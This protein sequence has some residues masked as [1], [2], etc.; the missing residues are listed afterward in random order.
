M[1]ITPVSKVFPCSK[2]QVFIYY[3]FFA[4]YYLPKFASAPSTQLWYISWKIEYLRTLS[5]GI[6]KYS[7]IVQLNIQQLSKW[8]V[9]FISVLA[10]STRYLYPSLKIGY[11]SIFLRGIMNHLMSNFLLLQA[12]IIYILVYELWDRIFFLWYYDNISQ[13]PN[14]LLLRAPRFNIQVWKSNIYRY[15]RVVL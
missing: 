13:C 2:Q 6:L 5:R 10:S 15:I 3:R 9:Y 12:P 11:L 14:F 4:W 7:H 1:K 8:N